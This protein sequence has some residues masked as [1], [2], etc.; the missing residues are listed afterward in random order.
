MITLYKITNII[1]LKVYIGMTTKT[2]NERLYSHIRHSIKPKFRLH[3]A[4]K[5]YGEKNFI[6]ETIDET[7]DQEIAN[8][9]EKFWIKTFNSTSYGHGYNMSLGGAGKSL[10]IAE[11]TRKKI[12]SA[13]QTNRNNLSQEEKNNLT[14]SA[15]NAKRGMKESLA[16]KEKKSIAQCK[17][18]QSTSLDQ[19]KIHGKKSR[20]GMSQEGIDKSLAALKNSYSSAREPGLKK[21]KVKCPYCDKIGGKP[22]MK[23]HHFEN[24]KYKSEK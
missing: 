22:I 5:K 6:I 9:L 21:E 18:W 2:I 14:K 3:H 12:K 16:S 4:I 13:V 24:C 10:L 17:R 1:N 23:R 15:N 7:D 20:D 11:E 8:E 19:K